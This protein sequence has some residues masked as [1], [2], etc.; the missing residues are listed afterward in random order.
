LVV[1]NEQNVDRIKYQEPIIHLTHTKYLGNRTELMCKRYQFGSE[2]RHT[3]QTHKTHQ[4]QRRQKR[5]LPD[6]QV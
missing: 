5:N 3:R 6:N 4:R 1:E 2:R